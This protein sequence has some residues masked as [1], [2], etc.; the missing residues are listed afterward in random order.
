VQCLLQQYHDAASTAEVMRFEPHNPPPLH[1][2]KKKER[3]KKRK[4]K[5]GIFW[6]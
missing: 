1:A 3:K 2:I 5:K 4:Q 6:P